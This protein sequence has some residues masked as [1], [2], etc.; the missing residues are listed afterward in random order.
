MKECEGALKVIKDNADKPLE[1]RNQLNT[2]R[3]TIVQRMQNEQ[4]Q[5]HHEAPKNQAGKGMAPK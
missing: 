1:V 2:M 3:N 4:Q 5:M